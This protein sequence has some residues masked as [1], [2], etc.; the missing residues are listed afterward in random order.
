MRSTMRYCTEDTRP[1]RQNQRSAL[2]L[3]EQHASRRLDL[4]WGR[5]AQASEHIYSSTCTKGMISGKAS[6]TSPGANMASSSTNSRQLQKNTTTSKSAAIKTGQATAENNEEQEHKVYQRKLVRPK[7]TRSGNHREQKSTID[8]RCSTG[9]TVVAAD[10]RNKGHALA[11]L[12]V[13]L[14]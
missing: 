2:R 6:G 4:V 9:Q 12:D 14:S 13:T 10:A 7:A 1:H 5:N 8:D 3:N 11:W